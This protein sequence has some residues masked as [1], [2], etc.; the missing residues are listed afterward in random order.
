M[1]WYT[2]L[3]KN[4]IGYKPSSFVLP[5]EGTDRIDD[6]IHVCNW[7][8]LHVAVEFREASFDLF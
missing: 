2:S 1:S 8:I 5:T 7:H 6:T 3:I 4:C